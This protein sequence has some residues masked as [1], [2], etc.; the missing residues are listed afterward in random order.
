MPDVSGA[1]SESGEPTPQVAPD[2]AP[3][4]LVQNLGPEGAPEKKPI[5]PIPLKKASLPGVISRDADELF[6]GDAA[7]RDAS[8]RF[9]KAPEAIGGKPEAKPEPVEA[10]PE[11]EKPPAPPTSS[12]LVKFLG[13]DYQSISE[14][15]QAH[16]SLQGQFKSLKDDRD[17]GFSAANGWKAEADRLRAEVE[18]LK[19]GTPAGGQAVQQNP[20][21]TQRGQ[22]LDVD[23]LVSGIDM[24]AFERHAATSG[25]PQAGK[26]LVSETLRAVMEKVLPA[27]RA[28]FQQGLQP[29]Q[30]RAQ[31]AEVLQTV[32]TLVSGVG[33]LQMLD[34]APAFPELNDPEKLHEIGLVW[35]DAGLP[36]E[37]A[38]TRQGLISAVALYRLQKGLPSGPSLNPSARRTTTPATATYSPAP[39]S[40]AFLPAEPQSAPPNRGRSNLDPGMQALVNALDETALVDNTLGFT[41]N[42]RA[43]NL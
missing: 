23:A 12:T 42:R 40:A 30:D 32:N 16:R 7:G 36:P 39:G 2:L 29:F 33:Q 26:Y 5:K 11:A 22:S 13:K 31:E 18:A 15:E 10:K 37:A 17:Y 4:E 25:L 35:R 21:S 6:G 27:V 14:V 41:R 38:L 43:A 34:G 28:E 1:P 3:P 9:T 24:D 8:G 19:G 20:V